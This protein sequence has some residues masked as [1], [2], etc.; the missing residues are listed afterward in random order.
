VR[1]PVDDGSVFCGALFPFPVVISRTA[2]VGTVAV[3][4]PMQFPEWWIL[5]RPLPLP[6]HCLA[7]GGEH[8]TTRNIGRLIRNSRI[9]HTLADSAS[10]ILE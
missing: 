1:R 5:N 3:L 7:T 2:A 9:P 8:D 10:P 6:L 4:T